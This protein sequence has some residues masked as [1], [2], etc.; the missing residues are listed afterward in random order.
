VSLSIASFDIGD[1]DPPISHAIADGWA[2]LTAELDEFIEAH[3]ITT[4]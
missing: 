1:E 2:E 4:Q 3:A